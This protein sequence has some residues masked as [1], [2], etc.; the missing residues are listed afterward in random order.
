MLACIYVLVS[1][2]YEKDRLDYLTNYF[3]NNNIPYPIKLFEPLY[4]GRDDDKLNYNK[5]KLGKV[6]DI[7]VSQSFELLLQHIIQNHKEGDIIL[8]LE[9]DVIFQDMFLTKLENIV[10]QF[11]L[12]NKDNAVVFLGDGCYL[13]IKENH[14]KV[15]DNLYE[16]GETKCADSIILTYN[17]VK[18]IYK[19]MQEL[20]TINIP[21][22][23][24]WNRTFETYNI[25]SYWCEPPII[26]QGSQN[27]TY[28]TTK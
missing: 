1:K 8:T 27:G 25:N 10:N 4:K 20:E 11:E 18:N 13:Q 7:A 16:T 6:S 24:L 2:E 17:A 22:D 19:H 9:S 3:N 23:W 14:I 15:S 5:Y 12:L 28:N 21:F 26:H